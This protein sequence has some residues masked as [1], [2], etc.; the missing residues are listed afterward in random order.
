[1]YQGG[2]ASRLP[3]IGLHSGHVFQKLSCPLEYIRASISLEAIIS[4]AAPK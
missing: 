3:I 2:S 4:V 1:M